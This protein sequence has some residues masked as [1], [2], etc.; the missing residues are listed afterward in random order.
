V[1]NHGAYLL[2]IAGQIHE[3][4]DNLRA[5]EAAMR[6]ALQMDRDASDTASWQVYLNWIRLGRLQTLTGRAQ[7]TLQSSAD[8]LRHVRAARDAPPWFVTRAHAVALQ[9][10][11]ETADRAAIEELAAQLQRLGCSQ[12]DDFTDMACREGLL[13]AHRVRG[14]RT[15]ASALLAQIEQAA[16]PTRGRRSMLFDSQATAD[17]LSAVARAH[18]ELGALE[19]AAHAVQRA[20]E[21]VATLQLKSVLTDLR[22]GGVEHALLLARGDSAAAKAVTEQLRQRI[23]AHPDRELLAVYERALRD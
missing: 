10:A 8:V 5:A 23:A 16:E 7:A 11:V 22:L 20:H 12:G 3:A 15:A 21:K 2:G 19:Q 1:K 4:N 17:M 13:G 6:E 9:S 18:L 14:E